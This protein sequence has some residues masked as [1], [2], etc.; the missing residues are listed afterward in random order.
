V[1]QFGV[2]RDPFKMLELC[3]LMGVRCPEGIIG[4]AGE[5]RGTRNEPVWEH[6]ANISKL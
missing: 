4:I 6:A 5:Y 2:R 1:S 3:F